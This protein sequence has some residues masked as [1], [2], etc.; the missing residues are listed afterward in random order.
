MTTLYT[1]K[2]EVSGGRGGRARSLTG[3]L[4]VTL[5]RP[6][7]R[8]AD[9]RGTDPEE[10]FAA[11]YAACFDSALQVAARTE[12]VKLGPTTV[13]ASVS[14]NATEDKRYAIAVVLEVAAP[15][16]S[17]EDLRRAVDTADTL[18]PYSN[19]VRGNTPV[20]I[21]LIG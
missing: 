4:E 6:A 9:A 5:T 14:L 3:G 10:L 21:R 17:P 7:E 2:V 1:A 15:E 11:G 16:A 13:T 18:C 19:A 20:E 12:K 8:G